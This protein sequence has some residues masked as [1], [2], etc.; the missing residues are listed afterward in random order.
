M[1]HKTVFTYT[2]SEAQKAAWISF[3]N[4]KG[5]LSCMQFPEWAQLTLPQRKVCY[6]LFYEKSELVGISTII[7]NKVVANIL[8][9]PVC[10]TPEQFAQAVLYIRDHYKKE[11][12]FIVLRVT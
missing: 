6:F 2:L 3:Y 12:K 5:D 1:D 11:K 7:E 10:N 8:H 4:S 9:G